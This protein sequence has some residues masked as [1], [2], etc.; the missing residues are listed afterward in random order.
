[1]KK[2]IEVLGFVKDSFRSFAEQVEK[3]AE[4]LPTITTNKDLSGSTVRFDWP[5]WWKQMKMKNDGLCAVESNNWPGHY[6]AEE[7]KHNG[8]HKYV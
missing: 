5:G 1:M 3:V 2:A 7:V 6:C 8:Y 4:K